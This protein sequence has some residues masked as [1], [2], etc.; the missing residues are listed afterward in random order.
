MME[1][2]AKRLYEITKKVSFSENKLGPRT[3]SL[4]T[5][6][7]RGRVRKMMKNQQTRLGRTASYVVET[8]RRRYLQE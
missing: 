3:A 6:T 7:F 1:F 5:P 8:R 2:E 4:D